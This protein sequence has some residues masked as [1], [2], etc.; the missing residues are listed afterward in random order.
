MSSITK[1]QTFQ[2]L[3]THLRDKID[4]LQV[5]VNLRGGWAEDT[6]EE[7]EQQARELEALKHDIASYLSTIASA[8]QELS[9]ATALLKQMQQLSQRL[10]HMKEYLPQR[11]PQ[12]AP[13]PKTRSKKSPCEESK[14]QASAP[15]LKQ[16]PKP[17]AQKVK[18]ISK[19]EFITTEEFESVPK[20][21]RGRLQYA[22]VNAAVEEVNKALEAKYTLL[23]RPRAKLS[24]LNMKIVGECRRQENKE[25]KGL[26]FVVDGDIK[27]WSSLKLDTAGKALLT[28]L[29][30]LK[31]LREVRGPGNLVRYAVLT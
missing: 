24:E 27:R 28:V 20:Y 19:V 16:T 30:T 13:Q 3:D 29:R 10:M 21:I 25:T 12:A 9:A 11:M 14:D 8:R 5:C 7:V 2:D 26:H 23:S 15:Q 31:R 1:V 6:V 17:A 18:Q 22:Q 4:I